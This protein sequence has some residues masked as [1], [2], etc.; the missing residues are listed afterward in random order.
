ML[1]K[2]TGK[3]DLTVEEDCEGEVIVVEA[4]LK[5]FYTFDYDDTKKEESEATIDDPMDDSE[6]GDYI[7]NIA[8]QSVLFNAKVYTMAEEYGCLDLSELARLKFETA[9]QKHWNT[10]EFADAVR[11]VYEQTPAHGRELRQVIAHV[12][13]DNIDVLGAPEGLLE[14]LPEEVWGVG[15]DLIVGLPRKMN[16]WREQRESMKMKEIALANGCPPVKKCRCPHCRK[17]VWIESLQESSQH[18]PS[19]GRS[20]V[21][22]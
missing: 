8:T 3:I 4:M 18:C 13:W 7:A 19:C 11:Y 17:D 20:Y 14:R 16:E 22:F 9:V 15:K 2:R 6:D 12:I 10:E 1:E 21:W 5:F